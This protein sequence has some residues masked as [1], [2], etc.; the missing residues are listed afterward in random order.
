MSNPKEQ[1]FSVR[2]VV[3]GYDR[4][5]EELAERYEQFAFEKVHEDVLDL[6][7]E[8]G[9]SVLDVGA[10]SGRDAAWFASKGYQV[11]A[12]E[13]SAKFLQ[14]AQARH[15]GAKIRWFNDQLPSIEKVLRSKLTF[16]L[17]WL[18]AMW[19]HVPPG[20]RRRAFRKLVSVMSP[21]ASMMLSLRLGP[22]DPNRPMHEV[23]VDEVEKLAQ[24][25]GLQVT[26]V[27]KREDLQQRPDISWE[28]VWLRLP[29]DGT[30]ALPLLRHVVFNDSKST[31]YKLG[32]LRVLVRIADGASGFARESADGD[33]IELPL[34]LVALYWIRAYRPLIDKNLPQIGGGKGLGFVKAAFRNLSTQSPY[35]LRVGQQFTGGNAR[36]LIN[37][38][39]DAAECILKMPANFTTFPGSDDKVF[40]GALRTQVRVFDRIQIDEAFLWSFGTFSLPVNLWRAMGRYAPWIEPAIV[41]EWIQMIRGYQKLNPDPW[42]SLIKGLE[43]LEPHH[44]TGL[45]RERAESLRKRGKPL[46]CVWTGKRLRQSFAIDHCFPF[47]AWPCN[48]LWNLLPTAK[49]VNSNKSDRLPSPEALETAR[50][51]IHEWWNDAYLGDEALARRFANESL[52]AL[53]TVMVEQEVV[54]PESV[55]EG[56]MVQQMVLR[57]DQQ[58]EEWT[59]PGFA[60]A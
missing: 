29:D 37:A 9:A 21:G 10:G 49:S 8:A 33:R 53:P 14:A 4:Q 42:D 26:R 2:D 50:P 45:V 27:A 40:L 16:D 25:Y 12:V 31:T 57:R 13:P 35:D 55:F 32:L 22:P 58:L 41:T 24:D 46:Y 39:R 17:V 20:Q 34:G 23:S 52:S 30:N 11:A 48:D 43:W 28:I 6:L 47:A 3:A 59:P 19:M 60:I 5:A 1:S 54:T 18:S 51:R 38:V 56:L 7:P 15:K 36:N 44:D